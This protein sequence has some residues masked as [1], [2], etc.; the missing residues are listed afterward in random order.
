MTGSKSALWKDEDIADI[1]IDKAKSFIISRKEEPFLL[2]MDTQDVHVPH[3]PHPHF[4]GKSSLG[5]RGDVILQLGWTIGETMNILDSLQL[6]NNTILVLTSDNGPVI[7]N[8][9]Q[10]QVLRRFNGHT[11]MGIYCNGKYSVYGA[12]TRTPS[13]IHRPTKVKSNK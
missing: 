12:G 1:I 5:T 8:G 11:S 6:T 2:Y 3:V 4:A 9:Y 13:I 10:D 7:D